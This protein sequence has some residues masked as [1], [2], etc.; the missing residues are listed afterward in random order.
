MIAV[1]GEDRS[2]SPGVYWIFR[3]VIRTRGLAETG[4]RTRRIVY[5]SAASHDEARRRALERARSFDGGA[6]VG[7]ARR[8]GGPYRVH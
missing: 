4:P 5:V 2:P 6:T 1:M 7:R 8:V 3:V